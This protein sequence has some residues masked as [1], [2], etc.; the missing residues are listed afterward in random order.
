MRNGQFYHPSRNSA[1]WTAQCPHLLPEPFYQVMHARS[2]WAHHP[3]PPPPHQPF[4]GETTKCNK[5]LK[6]PVREAGSTQM[7]ARSYHARQSRNLARKVRNAEVKNLP[8][9]FIIWLKRLQIRTCIA[10]SNMYLILLNYD[11]CISYHLGDQWY[12]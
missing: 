6:D 12:E 2:G 10:N 1:S 4:L 8:S 5:F 3:P 7:Q 9:K 11:Y